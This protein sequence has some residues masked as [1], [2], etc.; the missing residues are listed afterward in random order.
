M[1]NETLL[2]LKGDIFIGVKSN[3][4]IDATAIVKIKKI[5]AGDYEFDPEF[6]INEDGVI[7]EVDLNLVRDMLLNM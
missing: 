4:N 5:I 3:L 7:D 2:S 1:T 6:D